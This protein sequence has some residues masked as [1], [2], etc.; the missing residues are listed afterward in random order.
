MC[1]AKVNGEPQL[2]A[3]V[4]AVVDSAGRKRGSPQYGIM[5]TNDHCCEPRCL[6]R[7]SKDPSLSFHTFPRKEDQRKEW[8][9]AIRRDEGPSF[10]VTS[11]TVVCGAH[12]AAEDFSFPSRSSSGNVGR[13]LSS[14]L[15][16]AIHSMIQTH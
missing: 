15:K 13:K 12:F 4:C 8:I 11:N 5:P 3:R 9:V 7:R 1:T 16:P 10:S 14:F 2:E 6:N